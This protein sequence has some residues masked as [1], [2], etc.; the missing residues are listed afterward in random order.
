MKISLF[1]YKEPKIQ[2]ENNKKKQKKSPQNLADL[3][4]T[5]P[6][7][8]SSTRW[9]LKLASSRCSPR[10]PA[11]RPD[12]GE[13]GAGRV[14]PVREGGADCR[15]RATA[16]VGGGRRA[17]EAGRAAAST[18]DRWMLGFL[19]WWPFLYRFG[20]GL[21]VEFKRLQGLFCK[22]VK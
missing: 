15:R 18:G 7:R 4:A 11:V 22:N 6:V 19:G 21:R 5:G 17:G 12:R 10:P 14:Q 1:S 9:S 2:D 8:Q 13:G 20:L 16:V 3:A